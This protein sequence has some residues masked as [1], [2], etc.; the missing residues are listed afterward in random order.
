MGK[1]T[2]FLKKLT[3]VGKGKRSKTQGFE[4]SDDVK[5]EILQGLGMQPADDLHFKRGESDKKGD[6]EKPDH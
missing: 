6:Q 2:G 3:G 5:K 1:L 4:L